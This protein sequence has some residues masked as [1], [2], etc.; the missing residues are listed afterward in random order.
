MFGFSWRRR[1]ALAA[2]ATSVLILGCSEMGGLRGASSAQGG[3]AD[4]ETGSIPAQAN[5]RL[6]PI[7]TGVAAWDGALAS[8]GMTA[9][10]PTLP[11]DSWVR[12]TNARTGQ[13]T[14]VQVDRRLSDAR[15]RSIELSR[16]A[17]A[18]VGALQNGVATVM[19]EP[20]EQ[21]RGDA[22]VVRSDARTAPVRGPSL[23]PSPPPV[24]TAPVLPPSPSLSAQRPL[25]TFPRAEYDPNLA[26]GAI[27]TTATPSFGAR[28]V[29]PSF[30]GAQSARYLQLGAF[31]DPAN[32]RRL[33]DRLE[34]EGLDNSGYGGAFVETARVNGQ[35]FHR[36]RIGPL[37]NS[38]QAERALRDAQAL[39]HRGARLVER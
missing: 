15:G 10:H 20:V 38:G 3:P 19:I 14:M 26:T 21:L 27:P 23:I 18:A 39:G 4:Y 22:S 35:I 13:S 31:R 12:V 36:V 16:D 11:L 28:S 7:E 29:A 1:S 17:A 32:A 25:Q 33:V 5:A 6:Y 24:S 30:L 34:A 8:E 37:V 2:F 9:A